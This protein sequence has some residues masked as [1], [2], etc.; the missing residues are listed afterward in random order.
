MKRNEIKDAIEAKLEELGVPVSIAH[1][2]TVPSSIELTLAISGGGYKMNLRSGA[3]P[4]IVERE[5]EA[6]ASAYRSVA[7]KQIHLE[8]AIRE[9]QRDLDRIE[10]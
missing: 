6:L 5:L 7:N 4:E 10:L 3:R 1:I 8:D 9:A 2:R